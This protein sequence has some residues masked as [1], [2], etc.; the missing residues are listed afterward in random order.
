MRQALGPSFAIL[1]LGCGSSSDAQAP[2][3][4]GSDAATDAPTDAPT[5]VATD[6][7]RDT[8][9]SDDAAADSRATDAPIGADALDA[10]TDGAVDPLA[11]LSGCLGTSAALTVSRQMPYTSVP[12]GAGA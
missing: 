9:S 11:T 4:S 5:D 1:L 10:T 2:V 12:V 6:A 8:T 7:S 3:D